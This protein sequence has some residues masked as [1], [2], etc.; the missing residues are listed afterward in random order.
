MTKLKVPFYVS[1]NNKHLE[2][3]EVFFHI[4]YHFIPYQ[5]LRILG[6][7]KPSYEL[8]D[9]CKF[10]SMGEQ[11]DVSEWST[12]L[13]K[14]FVTSNDEYFIYGTED[15]FFYESP[16]IDY[17]NYLLEKMKESGSIGRTQLTDG[18]EENDCTLE[19]SHHYKVELVENITTKPWGDFKLFKQDWGSNYTINTQL[20]LWNKDYFLK[21]MIDGMTPWQFEIDGSKRARNNSDYG[22][23]MVDGA[24][25]IKK[26]EG[27]HG[28]AWDNVQYWIHAVSD[29]FKKRILG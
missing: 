6:Y 15:V 2:C 3:L 17:I 29:K 20:S 28:E 9:N 21:Y 24:I 23:W 4:F 22:V 13:R 10:I 18:A 14:Y 8:P 5:E 11:G 16:Q 27:Y 1:T 19:T 7:D 25:P 12:D 26:K